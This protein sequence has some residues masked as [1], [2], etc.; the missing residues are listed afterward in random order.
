MSE[1]LPAPQFNLTYDVKPT[2][3]G[4]GYAKGITAAGTSLAQAIGSVSQV[5]TQNRNADDMLTAMQANKMITPDEYEA[6][7]GKSLGAKQQLLGMYATEYAAQQAQQRA[8]AQQRG[9]GAVDI[10]VAHAKLLDTLTQL[11]AGYSADPRKTP[12]QPTTAATGA[13]TAATGALPA[14]GTVIPSQIPGPIAPG[15]KVVQV[16]DPK[17]NLSTAYQTPSGKLID[18]QGNVLQ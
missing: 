9:G 13:A 15:T 5:Y 7:A 11:R 4:E 17:G 1:Y 6:V 10:G 2:D 14:P 16:K 18:M 12:Y 8:L 3:I